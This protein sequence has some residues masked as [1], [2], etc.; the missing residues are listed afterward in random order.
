MKKNKV[1]YKLASYSTKVSLNSLNLPLYVY[2][3]ITDA[4]NFKCV[5]C[6]RNNIKNEMITTS[7]FKFIIDTLNN[8]SIKDIYITGGEPLLHPNFDFLI[9][10]AL[11]KKFN[12]SVLTNGYFINEHIEILKNV[13][14]V[15]V[16]LHGKKETHNQL[17]SMDSYDRVVQNILLIKKNTNV[18][19]NYTAFDKNLN[20]NDIL[21][22]YHLCTENNIPMY[23]SKY[24]DIGCGKNNG[25]KIELNNFAS[26]IDS[27]M[28]LKLNIKINN[29]LPPC[30]IDKKYS[31]LSHGCGAGNLFCCID[32]FLNLKICSSSNN[33]LGNL[34]KTKFSKIWNCRLLKK[35]RNLEWLSPLCTSCENL[36][37]CRGGCKV[38]IND[39]L[40]TMNDLNVVNYHDNIWNR[41]KDKNFYVCIKKLRKERN[42]YINLSYPTRIF[43][44]TVKQVLDIINSSG[45]LDDLEQYKQLI[46]ALYR[47]GLI[48][49]K[50]D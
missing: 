16:S 24:N 36:A 39:E 41:I 7:N 45:K 46:L 27:L 47:D 19:I 22:V 4:C 1:T 31:Y 10:Y 11:E 30:V 32:Q 26:M 18:S 44:E 17:V 3:K 50:Y 29:C 38:E 25:C 20:K 48:K 23:I 49:E 5:F 8:L 40:C 43:N 14:C 15:S 6:S 42:N 21:S 35:F 28:A 34:R 13:A 12:I 33:C 2:I 37:R 9:N